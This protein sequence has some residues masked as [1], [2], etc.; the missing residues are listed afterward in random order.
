MTLNDLEMKN[1]GFS[2]NFSGLQAAF[3]Q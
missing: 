2:V 3:K 1:N